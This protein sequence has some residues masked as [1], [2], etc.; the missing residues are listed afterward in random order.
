MDGIATDTGIIIRIGA[1]TEVNNIGEKKD[2]G[3]D[4][5]HLIAAS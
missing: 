5:G 2:I 3:R 4:K 1:E